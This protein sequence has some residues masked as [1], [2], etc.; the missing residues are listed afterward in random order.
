M[1]SA[2]LDGPSLPAAE[3]GAGE[4]QPRAPS[5]MQSRRRVRNPQ[6]VGEHPTALTTSG[7]CL[8][9]HPWLCV[10]WSAEDQHRRAAAQRAKQPPSSDLFKYWGI[11]AEALITADVAARVKGDPMGKKFQATRLLLSVTALVALAVE[12][13]AGN[14]WG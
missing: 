11:P 1:T 10:A 3:R 8:R 12:L 13:G 7:L 9:R 2:K 6:T 5:G 14:K 4:L